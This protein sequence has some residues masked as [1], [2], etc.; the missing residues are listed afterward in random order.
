MRTVLTILALVLLHALPAQSKHHYTFQ[1]LLTLNLTEVKEV[2]LILEK[3]LQSGDVCAYVAKSKSFE[4]TCS[5]PLDAE[6]IKNSIN[7]A[8]HFFRVIQANPTSGLPLTKNAQTSNEDRQLRQ[9]WFE[10][11]HAALDLDINTAVEILTEEEFN[12]LHPEKRAKIQEIKTIVIL[13]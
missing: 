5:A 12:T 7:K 3:Q 8:G 1:S 4:V 11:H 9:R 10:L 6:K 13:P 2:Q